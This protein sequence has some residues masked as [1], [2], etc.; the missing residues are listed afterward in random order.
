M[1]GVPKNTNGS[2]W[3]EDPP[4]SRGQDDWQLLSDLA[5]RNLA[6][7]GQDRGPQL[8][9]VIQAWVGP[10]ILVQ[11]SCTRDANGGALGPGRP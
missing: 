4:A 3:G 8:P 10:K 5:V 1:L 11:V 9:F 6:L 2:S 7:L